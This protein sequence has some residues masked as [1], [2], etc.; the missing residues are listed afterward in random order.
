M[1]IRAV[2]R[3]FSRQVQLFQATQALQAVALSVGVFANGG[4]AK[5]RPRLDV[6]KEQQSIHIPKTV[7]RQLL[8]K[9]FIFALVAKDLLLSDLTEVLNSGIAQALNGSLK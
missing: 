2:S 7:A 8:G 5:L 9:L 3:L 1:D 4:I 6:E